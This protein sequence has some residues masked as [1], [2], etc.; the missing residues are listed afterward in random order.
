[1]ALPK[2]FKKYLEWSFYTFLFFLF[3]SSGAGFWLWNEYQ[4]KLVELER[5]DPD[6]YLEMVEAAKGLELRQAFDHYQTIDRM[7]EWH[8]Y[9]LRYSKWKKRWREDAEF[10]DAYLEARSDRY[11]RLREERRQEYTRRQERLKAVTVSAP[12]KRKKA[13]QAKS[14]WEKTILLQEGCLRYLEMERKAAL[15]RQRLD[16]PARDTGFLSP[17]RV[18]G[19]TPAE[20]C[21]RLVTISHSEEIA[22]QSLANVQRSMNYYFF[23]VMSEELGLPETTRHD[24]DDRL[25]KMAHDFD[26]Y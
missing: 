5:K 10:K 26:A 23:T 7:T 12:E 6:R 9:T 25:A 3:L 19:S 4:P 13:W 15:K 24:I 21:D 1:M 14:P 18:V 16:H 20:E 2:R 11:D 8:V 17:E 22:E